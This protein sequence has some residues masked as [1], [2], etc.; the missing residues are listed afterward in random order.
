LAKSLGATH[1]FKAG[2][3]DI[4]GK[5]RDVTNGGVD[6]AFEMAGSVSALALAWSITSRGGQTVTSGLPHP[7][8][9]FELP[10]AQ[11]VAEERTLKGSYLGGCVPVRDI[12]IYIDLYQKGKLPVDKLMSDTITLDSINL[13]FDKLDS[14]ETVRQVIIFDD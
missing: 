10:A 2:D 7:D 9:I 4:V 13:A 5:V 3:E 1:T 8:K 6:Y 11:L 12:P 14:G